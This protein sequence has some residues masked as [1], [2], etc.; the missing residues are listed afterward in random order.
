M[1]SVL[2]CRW[3]G[4]FGLGG[5]GNDDDEYYSGRCAVSVERVLVI[6]IL[7]VVLVFLVIYLL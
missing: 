4:R 5:T 7:V 6:A 2:R 1:R 3:R